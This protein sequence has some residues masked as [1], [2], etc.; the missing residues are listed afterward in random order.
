M[1]SNCADQREIDS[2]PAFFNYTNH[3]QAEKRYLL[4]EALPDWRHKAVRLNHEQRQLD[5]KVLFRDRA[6]ITGDFKTWWI[7]L[8]AEVDKWLEDAEDTDIPDFDVTVADYRSFQA[9]EIK[10]VFARDE[11]RSRK[12]MLELD[13][14]EPQK[15]DKVDKIDSGISMGVHSDCEEY[16]FAT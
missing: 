3:L 9:K 6:G 10:K 5:T 7:A 14:P 12:I 4:E 13:I 8:T 2:E 11:R 1:T 15:L 16:E